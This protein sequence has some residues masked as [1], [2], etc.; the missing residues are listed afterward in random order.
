MATPDRD[1]RGEAIRDHFRRPRNRGRLDGATVV[2]T[3]DNPFCGD[4]VRIW[5]RVVDGVIGDVSF[6]G[7]GCAISQASASMLT[8]VAK[9]RPTS[10]V[11]AL[12]RLFVAGLRSGDPVL[13]KRL[14]P[15]RALAGIG[16]FPG[17]IRCAVLPFDALRQAVDLAATASESAREGAEGA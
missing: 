6:D 11:E 5:I 2:G 9:G 1:L 13:P 14:G 4:T 8:V 16:R 3:A 17:R 10:G 7:R 15:L 12:R